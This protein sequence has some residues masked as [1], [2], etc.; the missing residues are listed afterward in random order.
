VVE[1]NRAAGDKSLQGVPG[2]D[3]KTLLE[4]IKGVFKRDGG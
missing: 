2:D 3:G 1:L 4:R